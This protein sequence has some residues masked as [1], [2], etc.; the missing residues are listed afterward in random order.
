MKSECCPIDLVDF[1]KF[2]KMTGSRVISTTVVPRGNVVATDRQPKCQTLPVDL[3]NSQVFAINV[4]C[5]CTPIARFN[6]ACRHR[7]T[8]LASDHGRHLRSSSYRS[9][10]VP[11]TRTTFGDRSFTVAG[12]RLWNSLPATLRQLGDQ[13]RTV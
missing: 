4:S 10:A 1:K 2:A 11:R 8:C 9:L 3:S 12:P 7:P 5:T 13:L 6:G